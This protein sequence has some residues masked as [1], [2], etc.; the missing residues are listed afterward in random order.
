MLLKGQELGSQQWLREIF[1]ST[2]GIGRVEHAWLI[3]LV[4]ARHQRKELGELQW[5]N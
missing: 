3:A 2:R 1:Q 5:G 4:L